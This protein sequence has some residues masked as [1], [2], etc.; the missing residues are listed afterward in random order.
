MEITCGAT[1]PEEESVENTDLEK[2]LEI[3]ESE[4]IE[5]SKQKRISWA[6]LLSRVFAL[7]MRSSHKLTDKA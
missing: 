1:T 6:R 5:S 4:G 3:Q 2:S 7:N